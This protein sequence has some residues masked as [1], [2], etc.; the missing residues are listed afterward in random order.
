MSMFPARIVGL[1]PMGEGQLWL[2]IE[3]EKVAE[4]HTAVGQFCVLQDTS[5]TLEGIFALCN[6]PKAKQIEFLIRCST[7]SEGVKH[8]FGDMLNM[9]LHS[10]AI[11]GK[12]LNC[13]L[14]QGKGFFEAEYKTP[15]EIHRGERVVM[16]AAGTGLGPIR[17]LLNLAQERLEG[18]LSLLQLVVGARHEKALAFPAE[19]TEWKI[20]GLETHLCF[21]GLLDQQAMSVIHK[22]RSV[23]YIVVGH[24]AMR[25]NLISGLR[26]LG[27]QM[28]QFYHNH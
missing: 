1:E 17:A 24:E 20:R 10:N 21:G 23:K 6:R 25:K 7:Q 19:L 12:T 22:N 3:Q 28:H 15:L 14:P 5:S 9:Q 2:A 18:D 27:M 16:V 11:Q 8:E 26:T 13:T 4:K